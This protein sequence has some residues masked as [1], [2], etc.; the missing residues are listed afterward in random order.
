MAENNRTEQIIRNMRRTARKGNHLTFKNTNN[1]REFSNGSLGKE[2]QRATIVGPNHR[3]PERQWNNIVR[4]GITRRAPGVKASTP[5]VPVLPANST[6]RNNL[7]SNE[8]SRRYA[9]AKS[10]V[11][12]GINKRNLAPGFNA[13]RTQAERDHI[14]ALKEN[15]ELNVNPSTVRSARSIRPQS[16]SPAR[17]A[18]GAAGR[19]ALVTTSGG[20]RCRTVRTRRYIKK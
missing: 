2:F 11:K 17:T 1:V 13:A 8:Y 3:L 7:W 14:E 20:K 9:T 16:A 5:I 18:L 15:D 6:R 12:Q 4:A 19:A 10:N